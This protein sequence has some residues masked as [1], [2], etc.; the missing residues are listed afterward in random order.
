METPSIVPPNSAL[1][2]VNYKLDLSVG[3]TRDASKD[4]K[5]RFLFY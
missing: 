1:Q 5:K 2:L 4:T 3:H